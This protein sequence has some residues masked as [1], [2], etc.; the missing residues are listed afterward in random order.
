MTIPKNVPWAKGFLDENWLE[1]GVKHTDNVPHVLNKD[2]TLPDGA[3][4][5]AKQ[6]PDGHNVVFPSPQEVRTYGKTGDA[7][8]QVPRIDAWTHAFMT[9]DYEHHEVHAGS[10]YHAFLNVSGGSGTKATFT[11]TTPNTT[12]WAHLV[13]HFR[14][15]VES[16]IHFGEGATV[17]SSSGS[18]FAPLNKERNSN[19]TSGMISSGSAGGAGNITSGSAVTNFG[20]TL[21]LEHVGSGRA[22]GESRGTNEW[23][24]KQNTTYAIELISEA[25]SSELFLELHWYEHTN[26][27]A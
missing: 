6:L 5:A 4:T 25:A 17:T 1:Y 11:L 2:T 23:I 21:H 19:N 14:A 22:G 7:T 24:L 18:D 3:A 8:Y 13:I 16:N 15:S 27:S 20:T 26:R 10:S 9:L 12:K